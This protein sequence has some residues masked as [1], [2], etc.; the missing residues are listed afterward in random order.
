MFAVPARTTGLLNPDGIIGMLPGVDP[1]TIMYLQK[2]L[3]GDKG[4]PTAQQCPGDKPNHDVTTLRLAATDDGVNFTDLGP[5][6]GVNDPTDVAPTGTRYVGPR[7]TILA[8]ANGRFGL[9][10]SGGNCIDADS[11]ALHYIG[12]AES[13][14]MV[15]W[16]VVD[17]MDNPIASI[18]PVTVTVDGSS[19]TIPGTPPVVGDAQDWFA[20]R[21]YGPSATLVDGHTVSVVFSG[22]HTK[23]PKGDMGNY[24]TV[25][26]V[27]LESSR[28]IVGGSEDGD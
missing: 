5:V 4:Y 19:V 25:G 10:F 26:Q 22:Y 13:T 14:D 27:F 9:L 8:L 18:A 23:K 28:R 6:N 2:V 12:Y 1:P 21:V 7:G 24:R 20:G 11:D 16:R 17:G 3:D 15:N